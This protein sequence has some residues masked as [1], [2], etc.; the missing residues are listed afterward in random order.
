MAPQSACPSRSLRS[1]LR[2]FESTPEEFRALFR[3]TD[4]IDR[5]LQ[6]LEG[7]TDPEA[8][9]RREV[10]T[11]QRDAE[12]KAALPTERYEA[13][14]LNKDP[15]YRDAQSVA[16]QVG[17]PAD[18]VIPLYQIN[19]ASAIEQERIRTDATLTP[20]EQLEAIQIV[21]QEQLFTLRELL[22]D[23]AYKL[24]LRRAVR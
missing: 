20:E 18:A 3:V 10:L 12:I 4:A 5:R 22:G 2:G 15:I 24:Y 21:Q 16:R 17:A 7:S 14:A 19:Q 6:L 1:E 8:V 11:L 9:Q 23:E 13:Y